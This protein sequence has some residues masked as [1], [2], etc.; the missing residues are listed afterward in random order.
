MYEPERVEKEVKDSIILLRANPNLIQTAL[1]EVS[2]L[3]EHV[4]KGLVTLCPNNPLVLV[5]QACV[6]TINNQGLKL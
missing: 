6:L 2:L 5:V 4:E 1:I 3:Y